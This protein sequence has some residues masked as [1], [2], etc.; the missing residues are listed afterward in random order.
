NNELYV[1]GMSYPDPSD[2]SINYKY[3][4]VNDNWIP[5]TN[6]PLNGRRSMGCA[7]FNDNIYVFGGEDQSGAQLA[8]VAMYD[9]VTDTWTPKARM[10]TAR[11]GLAVAVVN[12]KIYAIGGYKG[13]TVFSTGVFGTVEEYDPITDTW[14]TRLAMP[15]PRARFAA[16]VVNN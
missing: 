6:P 14:N 5:G 2:G 11:A 1:I 16:A 13:G 4:P 3:D 7:V 10:P 15:T 8:D 9:P 12:D